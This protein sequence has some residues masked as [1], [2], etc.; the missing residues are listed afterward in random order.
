LNRWTARLERELRVQLP[1]EPRERLDALAAAQSRSG[2]MASVERTA[3]RAVLVERN[4]PIAAVAS[5][6]PILCQHEAALH[7][8]V[9]GRNVVLRSCCARGDDVCRFELSPASGDGPSSR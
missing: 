3:G 9:L 1:A 2:F 5:R 6:F 4:C 7:A 8:R